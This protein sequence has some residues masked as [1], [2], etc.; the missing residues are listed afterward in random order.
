MR[1]QWY[2]DKRDLVKWASLVYLAR[3]CRT[4]RIIQVPFSDG[5]TQP[6]E[7]CRLLKNESVQVPFPREVWEHFR[8][9][10][11]INGLARR[12]GIQIEV[13]RSRSRWT[14]KSRDQ[15]VKNLLRRLKKFTGTRLIVFL[16]P[17]TGIEPQKSDLRHV[18]KS[19][20]KTIFDADALKPGDYLV[21][22]QHSRRTKNW[23]NDTRKSLTSAIDQPLQ[24][25]QTLRY[26]G[27]SSVF[28]KEVAFH[29]VQKP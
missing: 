2:A 5:D 15:Y 25:V 7:K 10:E 6:W 8:R 26:L 4:S 14:N 9:Q 11:R 19:E 17:D 3:E 23:I 24:A 1:E 16:D 18:K 12:T 29:F 22:Y 13:F 20:I 21:L 28:T 27:D